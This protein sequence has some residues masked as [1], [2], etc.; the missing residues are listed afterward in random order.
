M[1]NRR[2]VISVLAIT[3]VCL[4]P[5]LLVPQA[6]ANQTIK[7]A[8]WNIR[9]LST[10]S[11]SD[12]ELLQIS[13]ILQ[14]YDFIAIQEVNDQEV[15]LR[16]VYWLKVLDNSYGSLSSPPSGTGSEKEHYTFL[17]RKKSIKRLGSWKLAEGD[18]A[19]PPFIASFKAGNFD[20]TVIS[21]HVC[22]TCNGLGEEG[23]RLEIQRLTLLYSNLLNGQEKDL[24]LMGDFN[25]EPNDDAFLNLQAI[26][27]TQPILTC[28]T[29]EDCTRFSTTRE[30]NLFDNM[31]FDRDHVN[32]YANEHGIFNFDEELFE[33]PSGNSSDYRERYA[34]LAVS[35]HRPIW[36]KFRIDLIDDD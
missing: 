2:S 16:L 11:R 5:Q 3:L 27:S 9:D 6:W 29:D 31:W 30:T 8:T 26:G 4:T 34:R 7:M 24:L 25:L 12:F 35:D 15:M 19:R 13:Y 17:Y 10:N 36:A 33:D 21:I 18:F 20:F 23:R 22:F 28:E 1:K 14:N 32:E